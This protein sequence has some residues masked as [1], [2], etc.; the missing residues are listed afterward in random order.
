VF[1]AG[2]HRSSRSAAE[3][4]SFHVAATNLLDLGD[5]ET[6]GSGALYQNF[7]LVAE[8]GLVAVKLLSLE[9]RW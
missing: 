9:E 7:R 4:I 6:F 5:G 8:I 2:L 1:A 3:E